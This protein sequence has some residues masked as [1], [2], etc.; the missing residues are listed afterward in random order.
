[1]NEKMSKEQV[2][3][4]VK[5]SEEETED[6]ALQMEDTVPMD[7]ETKLEL[8][9]IAAFN[10]GDI[11][12]ETEAEYVERQMTYSGAHFYES[13]LMRLQAAEA[14]KI[15]VKRNFEFKKLIPNPTI[16]DM[17]KLGNGEFDEFLDI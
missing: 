9:T 12:N 6:M 15:M 10:R 14:Y 16:D 1:M 5:L 11:P 7:Y 3:K 8:A 13:M 17:F 2:E 4:I